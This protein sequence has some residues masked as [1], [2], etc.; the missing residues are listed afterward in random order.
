MVSAR[1][2]ARF[3]AT[4]TGLPGTPYPAILAQNA[5]NGSAVDIAGNNLTVVGDVWSNSGIYDPGNGTIVTPPS[6][7]NYAPSPSSGC[8]PYPPPVPSNGDS[9]STTSQLAGRSYPV[10]Y[11]FNTAAHTITNDV[12]LASASCT[13]FTSGNLTIGSAA[14]APGIY[15]ATGNITLNGNQTIG[16][17]TLIAGG[18]IE[19]TG[20]APYN[21][22]AFW[23]NLLAFSTQVGTPSQ[24]VITFNNGLT[25]VGLIYAPNGSAQVTGNFGAT[26][27]GAVW[28]QTVRIS[29]NSWTLTNTNLGSSSSEVTTFEA[30]TLVE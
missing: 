4:T 7:M 27:N 26:S 20:S 3:G 14:P 2:V 17:V 5:C 13:S 19:A 16:N 30:G 11:T 12:T 1:A 8:G 23:D 25:F 9:Y 10:T 18:K 6:T 21:L 22:T 24:P 15:C 28:G 29:G